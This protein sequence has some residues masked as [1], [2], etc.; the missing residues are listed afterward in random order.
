MLFIYFRIFS[1]EEK[2]K[3]KKTF[4]CGQCVSEFSLKRN[5]IAHEKCKHGVVIEKKFVC[6]ICGAQFNYKYNLRKHENKK[7]NLR[8][9]EKKE[10]P[11]ACSDCN[12]KYSTKN[13]LRRHIHKVHTKV[14]K[15]FLVNCALCSFY[16][17]K[18]D[19]FPHYKEYHDITVITKNKTFAN[20]GDFVNWKEKLELETK[21]KFIKQRSSHSKH[22]Y[23]Y[24][25]CH[26][27]GFY[28]PKGKGLRHLK[29]QGSKKINSFCPA[30]MRLSELEDGSCKLQYTETHVGHAIECKHLY[31]TSA[32]RKNIEFRIASNVPFSD[33]LSEIKNSLTESSSVRMHNLTKKDLHNIGRGFNQLTNG[34]ICHQN[35]GANIESWINE[36]KG[37]ED[38]G[39]LFYK[40]QGI[41]SDQSLFRQED[42][43]LVIMNSTQAER[44]KKFG[45]DLII[46]DGTHITTNHGL[47]LITLLSTD[48]NKQAFPG[49]FL[50]SNRIDKTILM[51]FFSV[52][53]E[54]IG[55]IKAKV[56]MSDEEEIYVNTWGEIMG[57]PLK[58]LFSPWHVDQTW[59]KN[60]SSKIKNAKK[61]VEV[62]KLLRILILEPD[63]DAFYVKLKN[64]ISMLKEDTDFSDFCEYFVSLY[65]T[66]AHSWA[67]CFREKNVL[68]TIICFERMHHTLRRI[69]MRGKKIK[70]LDKSLFALVKLLCGKLYDDPI[71]MLSKG[72]IANKQAVILK[73]HEIAQDLPLTSVSA[74]GIDE[75]LVQSSSE[76]ELCVVKKNK[77]KETCICNLVCT[78]CGVCI[79]RYSCTCVDSNIIGNMCEHIHLVCY[80]GRVTCLSK[81]GELQLSEVGME[82]QVGPESEESI[83]L[84]VDSSTFIEPHDNQEKLDLT[85]RKNKIKDYFLQLLN[86]ASSSK[87]ID[88]LEKSLLDLEAGFFTVQH[89]VEI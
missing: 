65:V 35:D 88:A 68:N 85:A 54:R 6:K 62:Y 29:S 74:V 27:S 33:I 24:F 56:L 23:Q 71:L 86:S 75:W 55:C 58:R 66:K 64:F 57:S 76:A 31:L 60:I 78:E 48:D 63:E 1:M 39:V 15:I 12:S 52:V 67:Y 10:K 11:F 37:E 45:T 44:V 17:T 2:G 25:I 38:P 89:S 36:M 13:I 19:M 69:F 43:V 81:E 14:S 70:R 49:A 40:P 42:L 5:L 50:I 30:E 82:I 61:K 46:I 53:K 20:F 16:G 47:Q 51:K 26:R 3:S 80:Y 73:Q 87:E 83:A 7:H 28:I 72:K 22:K 79:H 84:I 9:T 32:E 18:K 77:D 4:K 21:S 59:R 41:I 34:K 8:P